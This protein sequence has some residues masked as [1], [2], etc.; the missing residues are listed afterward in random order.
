MKWEEGG[1]ETGVS[2]SA[3]IPQSLLHVRISTSW[4]RA[5]DNGPI[6]PYFSAVHTQNFTSTLI[7]TCIR[8]PLVSSPTLSPVQ[9]NMNSGVYSLGLTFNLI[10]GQLVWKLC[11][12]LWNNLTSHNSHTFLTNV[13]QHISSSVAPMQKVFQECACTSG[14]VG[15]VT[16][17]FNLRSLVAKYAVHS[18]VK[19]PKV[20]L[21]KTKN[22]GPENKKSLILV[23]QHKNSYNSGRHMRIYKDLMK[24]V[25]NRHLSF[26]TFHANWQCSHINQSQSQNHGS[27]EAI[28]TTGQL[29]VSIDRVKIQRFC[30]YQKQHL[31]LGKSHCIS[32]SAVLIYL[33]K[34]SDSHQFDEVC[35]WMEFT[36]SDSP[37][38]YIRTSDLH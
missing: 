35:L 38:H 9:I 11:R 5:C 18:V 4:S 26:L 14:L 25:S 7:T 27:D 1:S 10:A 30:R 23:V 33:T 19:P 29:T 31:M 17:L 15:P 36:L 22:K 32:I 3:V 16:L 8:T 12:S 24:V 34:N 20:P 2:Q 6:D 37:M 28:F 21:I 13:Q